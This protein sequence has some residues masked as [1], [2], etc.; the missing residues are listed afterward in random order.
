MV[1][2]GSQT[3]TIF[4]QNV[5]VKVGS[6]TLGMADEYDAW[7][8]YPVMDRPVFGSL[9]PAQM[10]QYFRGELRIRGL[11]TTDNALN[12]NLTPSGGDLVLKTITIEETDTTSP[13]PVKKTTTFTGRQPRFEKTGR[14]DNFS[15]FTLTLK[16]TAEWSIA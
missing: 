12:A 8:E 9:T 14:P 3:K 10:P 11:W 2:I 1:T 6:D 7:E 5:V 4:G 15:A 16:L 13:T